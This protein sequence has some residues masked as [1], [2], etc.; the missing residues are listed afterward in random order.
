MIKINLL[1]EKKI[2][3]KDA[4]KE[5]LYFGVAILL[6]VIIFCAFIYKRLSNN[7]KNVDTEIASVTSDTERFKREIGEID[8][9]KI[10]KENLEKKLAVVKELEGGR[11][12][13]VKIMDELSSNVPDKLWLE[14]VRE[15]DSNIDIEG[16]ALDNDTVATFMI[17]LERS[18]Y[19][20]E[21]DLGG[22]EYTERN[23]IKLKKFNIRCNIEIPQKG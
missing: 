3:R 20:K 6:V 8:K 19:F 18:P 17:N 21:V 2:T 9:F 1:K 11:K 12:M 10:S 16:V 5:E 23:K 7:I 15:G 22:I 13:I 14:S 4:I